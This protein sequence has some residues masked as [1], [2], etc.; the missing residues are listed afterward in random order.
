MNIKIK[1]TKKQLL[2]L[3]LFVVVIGVAALL[4]SYLDKNPVHFKD[5]SKHFKQSA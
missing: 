3:A 4:D 1:I 5:E 2:K